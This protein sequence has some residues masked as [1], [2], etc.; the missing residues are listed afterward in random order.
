VNIINKYLV[1]KIACKNALTQ[2]S[3]QQPMVGVV[4]LSVLLSPDTYADQCYAQE[5]DWAPSGPAHQIRLRTGFSYR[6]FAR[7]CQ[8]EEN[9]LSSARYHCIKAAD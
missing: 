9:A 3:S 6:Y 4:V 5:A 1:K 7:G 8:S 2:V